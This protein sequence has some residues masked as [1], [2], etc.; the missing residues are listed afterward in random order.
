MNAVYVIGAGGH[1]KVVTAALLAAGVQPA[2]LIDADAARHGERVLGVPVIR[3]DS[4]LAAMTPGETALY[5]GVGFTGRSDARIQVFERFTA[6]GFKFPALVHPD[7]FIAPEVELGDGAQ[8]MAGAVIQPGVRIGRNAIINTRASVDHDCVIGDHAHIAPGA[9]LSGGV[10]V[11]ARVLI[12][13]GASVIHAAAV[14][15]GAV[16]GAGAAVA[17]DIAP[18]VTA[19]GVPAA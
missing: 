13:V 17:G 19:V 12:G 11:G 10:T 1:A 2:G 6:Q 3:D 8:I 15:A 7:A 18:G 16:I 4:L 9:V 5:N 14:G